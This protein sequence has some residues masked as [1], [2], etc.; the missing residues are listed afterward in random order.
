MSEDIIPEEKV[1]HSVVEIGLNLSDVPVIDKRPMDAAS[2]E[3]RMNALERAFETILENVEGKQYQRQG[4]LK[5]PSRAANAMLF[6]TNGYSQNLTGM[7]II[8]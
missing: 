7:G 8:T 2:E 4:L 1:D 3:R 5:T 6:F